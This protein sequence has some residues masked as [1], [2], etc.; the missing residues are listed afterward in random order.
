MPIS[1][2]LKDAQFSLEEIHI[3]NNQN[4]AKNGRH[5]C[6]FCTFLQ[7]EV[8]KEAF[9]SLYECSCS[10][11]FDNFTDTVGEKKNLAE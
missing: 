8:W 6:S 3:L 1:I 4:A 7:G 11:A 9:D 2:C 10:L 5:S